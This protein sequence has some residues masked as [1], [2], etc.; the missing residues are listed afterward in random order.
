MNALNGAG[1]ALCFG[2]EA[3]FSMSPENVEDRYAE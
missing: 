3:D 1:A 2:S